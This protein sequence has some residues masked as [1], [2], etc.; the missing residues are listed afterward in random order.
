MKWQ[1]AFWSEKQLDAKY[2][3]A[4]PADQYHTLK[5]LMKYN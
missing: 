4:I 3:P 2:E 1:E 5:S